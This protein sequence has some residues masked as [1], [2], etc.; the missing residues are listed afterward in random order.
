MKK[1]IEKLVKAPEGAL[2]INHIAELHRWTVSAL[3][4]RVDKLQI[5]FDKINGIEYDGRSYIEAR[6]PEGIINE[7][8]KITEGF[9]AEVT[10]RIL[11]NLDAGYITRGR[12]E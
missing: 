2:R 8:K 3:G 1:E 9:M 5:R 10:R 4:E 11:S 12:R 6:E 7:V